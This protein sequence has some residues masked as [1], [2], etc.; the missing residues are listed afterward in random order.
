MAQR[1]SGFLLRLVAAAAARVFPCVP[2]R[3]SPVYT[4]SGA[5]PGAGGWLSSGEP[6]SVASAS[7]RFSVLDLAGARTGPARL[8]LCQRAVLDPRGGS[9]RGS[10]G[11]GS[12][13]GLWRVDCGICGIG[14]A[15]V[16]A[17]LGRSGSVWAA[18]AARLSGCRA[19]ALPRTTGYGDQHPDYPYLA[20]G[21]F[22][23]LDYELP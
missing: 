3:S 21:S 6:R 17:A 20:P 16:A 8:R 22:L 11:P 19:H 4:R 7:D 1:H 23:R 15:A 13:R 14:L 12:N 9:A 2:L 10:R 18:V 5:R